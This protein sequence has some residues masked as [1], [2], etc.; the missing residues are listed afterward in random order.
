MCNASDSPTFIVFWNLRACLPQCNPYWQHTLNSKAWFLAV[1]WTTRWGPVQH[2]AALEHSALFSPLITV[3]RSRRAALFILIYRGSLEAA[4][5]S[6]WS[7]QSIIG[8]RGHPPPAPACLVTPIKQGRERGGT[9][10][11][12]SAASNDFSHSVEFLIYTSMLAC[13]LKGITFAI[14]RQ[15]ADIW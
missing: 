5:V 2:R 15:Q 12:Q 11:L 8:H 4:Q 10:L 1:R 14:R 9:P 7:W 13:H 3:Q 6:T